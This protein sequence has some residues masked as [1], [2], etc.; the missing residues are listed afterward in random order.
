LNL[1]LIFVIAISF[2]LSSFLDWFFLEISFPI[3]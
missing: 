1:I 3:I 2:I